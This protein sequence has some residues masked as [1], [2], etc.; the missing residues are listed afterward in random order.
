MPASNRFTAPPSDS[1]VPVLTYRQIT[2][3]AD[4]H[5]SCCASG[6]RAAQAA[7]HRGGS[8]ERIG[9]IA[10]GGGGHV[11]GFARAG[12]GL[13]FFWFRPEPR[14]RPN[15]RRR[16]PDAARHA[17]TPCCPPVWG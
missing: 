9:A 6:S 11:G 15:H 7:A 3:F 12:V 1:R 2:D 13:S 4:R 5:V 10:I 14:R 8:N 16:P 17:E